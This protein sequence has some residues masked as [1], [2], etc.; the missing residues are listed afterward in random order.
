MSAIIR[1]IGIFNLIA[2]NNHA[3]PTSI[4]LSPYTLNTHEETLLA[5]FWLHPRPL[6]NRIRTTDPDPLWRRGTLQMQHRRL[7]KL[8]SRSLERIADGEE[9]T[10]A[11]EEGRFAY[12]KLVSEVI[13]S[14][15]Q[16]DDE[17]ERYVPTPLL[18]WIVLKFSH[19]TS[20]RRLTFS[21]WGTSLKPGIL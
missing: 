12:C 18:L 9:D 21:I 2:Y 6:D 20:F 4:L 10:A 13:S 5:L 15:T 11:H 8:R 7:A 17:R 3:L 16:V 19:S 1:N 14:Q